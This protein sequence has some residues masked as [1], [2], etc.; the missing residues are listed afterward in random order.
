MPPKAPAKPKVQPKP[1]FLDGITAVMVFPNPD[2]PNVHITFKGAKVK[3]RNTKNGP[4][5][6]L[7]TL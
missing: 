3:I 1:T 6:D 5:P 4:Q 7:T 2:G